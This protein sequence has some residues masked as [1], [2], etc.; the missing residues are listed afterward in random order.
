MSPA[1]RDA[2]AR[3]CTD[4]ERGARN[5][6]HLIDQTILPQISL[7]LL[8]QMAAGQMPKRVTLGANEDGDFRIEF[9]TD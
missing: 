3:R 6:D 7:K 2:L 5:I 1:A 8:E 9:A 4:S